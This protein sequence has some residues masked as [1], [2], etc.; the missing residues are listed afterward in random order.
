MY[1]DFARAEV[2]LFNNQGNRQ[3]C[4][5]L[6]QNPGSIFNAD[7]IIDRVPFNEVDNRA[8]APNL[9][10]GAQ[11]TIAA[12][13]YSATDSPLAFGCME[14]QTVEGGMATSFDLPLS[15]LDLQYKGRFTV[16]HTFNLRSALQ[17]SD[18]PSLRSVS[19]LM[20]YLQIIGG[21]GQDRA[22][23]VERVLCDLLDL[24]GAACRTIGILVG[25]GNIDRILNDFIANESPEL[26]EIFQALADIVKILEEMTIVGEFEFIEN[27]PNAEGRLQ[28]N[29][30][31]WKKFRFSWRNGCP[32]GQQ[33][34][35]REFTIGDIHTSEDGRE[36]AIFSPFNAQVAGR[37]MVI[38]EHT[39]QVRYG[40]IL[41]GIAENWVIPAILNENG[42]IGIVAGLLPCES[43]NNLV[44]D[45]ISAR[46]SS[47]RDSVVL[48]EVI[49]D[50]SFLMT[51]L[52]SRALSHRWMKM[53]T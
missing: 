13:A 25:N 22:E 21:Q 45:N 53:V 27:T 40:L 5:S 52:P 17:N 37:Q 20:D 44:G 9:M 39:M 15:D 29:D 16:L 48:H 41:L 34:E 12:L 23:A 3:N 24:G 26:L 43:I 42:P 33:C 2:L 49:S 47:L 11:Y 31:R 6:G 4:Q 1:R 30:D 10:A 35:N 32:P 46:T 28:N 8:V 18:D 14:G 50:L 19:Q 36:S 51:G 7:L 38:E